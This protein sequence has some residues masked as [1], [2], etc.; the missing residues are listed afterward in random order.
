MQIHSSRP[1]RHQL[2][3]R[4][5]EG[6][7]RKIRG[8]RGLCLWEEEHLTDLLLLVLLCGILILRYVT[9]R[10]QSPPDNQGSPSL[11]PLVPSTALEYWCRE[12]DRGVF[13]RKE[14]REQ[15]HWQDPSWKSSSILQLYNSER[16]SWSQSGFVRPR[17]VSLL[18][19]HTQGVMATP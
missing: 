6:S 8:A 1:Y 11:S 7:R 4:E 12:Q 5:R 16:L 3:E 10:L 13:R 14:E 9:S 17:N 18:Q 19:H 2:E 15:R